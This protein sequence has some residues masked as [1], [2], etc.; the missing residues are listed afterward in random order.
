[1]SAGAPNSLTAADFDENSLLDLAT[2][3]AELDL[4]SV[5][6]NSSTPPLSPDCNLNSLPD[7]CDI[8]SGRSADADSDGVPDECS[9]PPPRPLFH[10][11][12]PN[13]D[14]T[15]DISDGLSI[16]P[17]RQNSVGQRNP[18]DFRT[19]PAE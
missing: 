19:F 12:D 14:G 15:T 1:L 8:A 3:N 10:R 17:R 18:R 5:H 6:L 2:A 9:P 7:G 16:F 11:A 4:V 13:S